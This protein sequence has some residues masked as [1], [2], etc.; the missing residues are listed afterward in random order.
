MPTFERDESETQM[1]LIKL[2]LKIFKGVVAAIFLLE[3]ELAT[4][5]YYFTWFP[6]GR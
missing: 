3:G 2:Q 5:Y 1:A 4:S 6:P